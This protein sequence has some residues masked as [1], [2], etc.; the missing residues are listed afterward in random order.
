M[1]RYPSQYPREDDGYGQEGNRRIV[2]TRGNPGMNRQSSGGGVLSAIPSGIKMR[3]LIGLAIAAVSYFGYI[4][5]RTTNV[6]T[7][8]TQHISMSPQQEVAIGLEHAPQMVEQMGGLSRDRRMTGIVKEVGTELVRSMQL[9]PEVPD[10]PFD[11]HLLAD[12]KTVN[13]F[14]LPGGQVFITEALLTRLENRAQLA[15]VLGHEIG[16]VL[17]RH[18]AERMA[19]AQLG[20][21]IAGAVGVATSDGYGRSAGGQIASQVAGFMLLKYGREDELESDALGVKIMVQAGY[22]PRELIEVM[23]ILE[24]ASGGSKQPEFMATHPNPGNRA[25]RIAEHID[26]MFPNKA[27]LGRLRKD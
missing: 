9:P 10:Y 19:K 16:H 25:Q 15:G 26:K 11:F 21:G 20:Q 3:L 17:G 12:P 22:D 13:A 27:D 1:S 2:Y 24:Q 14:A 18:S 7:G 23:R 8:K 6:V 4:S 5:K